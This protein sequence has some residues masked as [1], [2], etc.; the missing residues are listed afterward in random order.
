[1]KLCSRVKKQGKQGRM[2]RMVEDALAHPQAVS[3]IRH[4]RMKKES[5]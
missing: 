2:K 5:H 1:M 3:V 4:T